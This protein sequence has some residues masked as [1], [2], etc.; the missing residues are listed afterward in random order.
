MGTA[1]IDDQDGTFA[2]LGDRL[3]DQGVVLEAL[4]GADRAKVRLLCHRS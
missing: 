3:L 1:R 4:D 2:G